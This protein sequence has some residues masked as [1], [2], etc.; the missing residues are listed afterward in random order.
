MSSSNAEKERCRVRFERIDGEVK[1]SSQGARLCLCGSEKE[2][3]KRGT[4][5][6]N[7]EVV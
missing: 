3:D 1:R 4:V 2:E 5:V 7:E 6:L